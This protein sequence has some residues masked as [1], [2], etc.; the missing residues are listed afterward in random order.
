MEAI[1][2]YADNVDYEIEMVAKFLNKSIKDKVEAEA[3]ELNMM[4]K[5]CSKLPL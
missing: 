4:K 3:D 1:I 5:K 2:M